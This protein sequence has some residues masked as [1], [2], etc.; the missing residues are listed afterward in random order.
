MASWGPPFRSGRIR[1][2][3]RGLTL[4]PEPLGEKGERLLESI[5]EIDRGCPPELTLRLLD[6]HG[7][8]LLLA[9][10]R[11][12][13]VDGDVGT[14]ALLQCRREVD[15]RRLDTSADVESARVE[16]RR[17]GQVPRGRREV[18]AGDILHEYVIARLRSI[19]EYS[20]R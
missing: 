6:A 4:P 14:G 5:V 18:G 16:P 10:T 19:A 20:Q 13:Q 9:G 11:R 15:H 12:R 2:R 8:T 3:S 1:A 7:G 17:R